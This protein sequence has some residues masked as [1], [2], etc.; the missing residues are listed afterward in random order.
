MGNGK[1]EI[2]T[3]DR[4][5]FHKATSESSDRGLNLK[6]SL[7]AASLG[8]IITSP[9]VLS[10][11]PHAS[12]TGTLMEFLQGSAPES[13]KYDCPALTSWMPGGILFHQG[14]RHSQT[15]L[16]QHSNGVTGAGPDQCKSADR[17]PFPLTQL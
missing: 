1:R 4:P 7:C 14:S 9:H 10:P 5:R 13:R 8:P 3:L 6:A 2:C 17:Q 16:F 12:A 11:Q 15:G